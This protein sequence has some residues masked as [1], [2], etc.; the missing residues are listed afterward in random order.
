MVFKVS[1]TADFYGECAKQNIQISD[2]PMSQGRKLIDVTAFAEHKDEIEA[3][4]LVDAH[5]VFEALSSG[6][7]AGAHFDCFEGKPVTAPLRF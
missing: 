3:G 7:I 1:I 6:A 4:Q 2:Y 5:A